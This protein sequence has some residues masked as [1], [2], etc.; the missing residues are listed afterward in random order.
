[1]MKAFVVLAL[2][3]CLSASKVGSAAETISKLKTKLVSHGDTETVEQSGM[4]VSSGKIFGYGRTKAQNSVGKVVLKVSKTPMMINLSPEDQQKKWF[5]LVDKSFPL[6]K[7]GFSQWRP[8]R[9]GLV[10]RTEDE[11]SQKFC[12]AAKH[13]GTNS[14]AIFRFHCDPATP[15]SSRFVELRG[16]YYYYWTPVTDG[17]PY[18]WDG[19]WNNWSYQYWAVGPRGYYGC[20][21]LVQQDWCPDAYP[22]CACGSKVAYYAFTNCGDDDCLPYSNVGYNSYYLPYCNTCQYINPTADYYSPGCPDCPYTTKS[23]DYGL[24]AKKDKTTKK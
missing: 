14:S 2:V 6:D 20:N 5:D 15:V 8:T 17:T 13:S 22:N 10:F 19:Y 24:L 16:R 18:G 23:Y 4:M 9:N 21:A 3:S 1:M 11:K 7:A 12:Q